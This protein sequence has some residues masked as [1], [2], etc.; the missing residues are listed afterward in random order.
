MGPIKSN[1]YRD[2]V[3]KDGKFIGAFE[4][5]YRNCPDPWHQD[6]VQPLAEDIA[7]LLLSK[8]RYQGVL[9]IGCGKGRFTNHLKCATGASVTALDISP[10]AIQI[11]RSR[12]PDIEFLVATVPPCNFRLKASTW[13]SPSSCSG[14][15]C[16]TC[17][18]YLRKSNEY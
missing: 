7:L 6:E 16:Q 11:A 4:E 13:W 14:T 10:T 18:C 12:Y 2:Y 9:D 3:I 8:R 1:D 5:M 15:C 17:R